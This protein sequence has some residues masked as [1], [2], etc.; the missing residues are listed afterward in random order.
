MFQLPTTETKKQN[1]PSRSQSMPEQARELSPLVSAWAGTARA[2]RT[3]NV[4]EQWS[5]FNSPIMANQL[6]ASS[7]L[8]GAKLLNS[9]TESLL[10]ANGETCPSVSPLKT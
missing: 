1:D 2:A 10:R 6:A 4:A 7:S 3:F 9:E 5:R 8:A